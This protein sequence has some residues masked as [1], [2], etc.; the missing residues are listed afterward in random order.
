MKNHSPS[1]N[2]AELE[3][4]IM[5]LC[6]N[7]DAVETKHELD[8][9]KSRTTAST[10][11]KI[12]QEFLQDSEEEG[13]D[14]IDDCIQLHEFDEMELADFRRDIYELFMTDG[15]MDRQESNIDRIVSFAGS[16]SQTSTAFAAICIDSLCISKAS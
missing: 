12:Y 11:D 5:L 7:A 16:F 15:V 3:I 9:I 13:L 10:F 2:K 4:Y 1:W 6:A 14:K 8:L